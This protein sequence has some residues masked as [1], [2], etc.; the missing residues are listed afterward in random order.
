MLTRIYGT[1]F[2]T[3]KE[4]KEHLEL[5]EQAK[6]RD[7]RKLGKELGLYYFSDAAPGSAFWTPAGTTRVQPARR[8]LT[9]D[10]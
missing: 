3:K 1:A 4:L 2:F 9:R 5:L 8:A 6:A 10:G 7:H